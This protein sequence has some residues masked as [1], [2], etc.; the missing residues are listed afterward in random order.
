MVRYPF[1][2]ASNV[3][4]TLH[5]SECGCL[6]HEI[7]WK[8]AV[9]E[10]HRA[11]NPF[12]IGEYARKTKMEQCQFCGEKTAI[13]L[14]QPLRSATENGGFEDSCWCGRNTGAS[15]RAIGVTKLERSD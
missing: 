1:G 11:A 6:V 2:D 10:K 8:A 3:S 14:R 5:S 9:P 15:R 12:V 13:C 4:S 7:N